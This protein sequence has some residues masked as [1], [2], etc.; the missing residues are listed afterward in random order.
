[1]SAPLVGKRKLGRA[2]VEVSEL[3]LGAAGLGEPFVRV[4]DD[5]AARLIAAAWQGDPRATRSMH[6]WRFRARRAAAAASRQ[7]LFWTLLKP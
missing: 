2:A 7:P 6:K 1:M 4:D 5:E 3:G